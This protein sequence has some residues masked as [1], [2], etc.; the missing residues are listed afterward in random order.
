MNTGFELDVDLWS[1]TFFFDAFVDVY[2]ISDMC[3]N[4]RT[5]YYDKSGMRVERPW[6]MAT[7]YFRSW[8]AIDFMSCLPLGYLGYFMDDSE[9]SANLR[10]IKAFRLIRLGKMLRLAR[11][12]KILTKYGNNVNLQSYLLRGI[13]I[14]TEPH[15][16][17][18]I[19]GLNFPLHTPRSRYINIGF[20]IFIILFLAHMLACFF[21]MVGSSG[22]FSMERRMISY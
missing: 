2:F 5:A 19:L 8:F 7:N 3:L 14:G 20:T 17:P 18:L 22:Q 4:F 6:R 15:N 12:K 9:G 1:I 13:C 16:L 10:A 21:Y 11:I